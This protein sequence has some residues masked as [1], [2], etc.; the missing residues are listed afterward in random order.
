M[1]EKTIE[2]FLKRLVKEEGGLCIKLIPAGTSGIPDRLVLLPGGKILFAELKAPGEKPR[3]I[4]TLWQKRISELGF[5]SVVIDNKVTAR[6]VIWNA[7]HTT[8]VSG[9]GD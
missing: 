2:D 7:V 4:Q 9:A 6:E 5:T 8:P 3:T 1:L